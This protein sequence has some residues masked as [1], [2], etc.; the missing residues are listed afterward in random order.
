MAGK[1]VYRGKRKLVRARNYCNSG[2]A[3][4]VA[5]RFCLSRIESLAAELMID[6][7]D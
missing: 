3:R 4:D 1:F 5:K 7:S 2:V 6:C